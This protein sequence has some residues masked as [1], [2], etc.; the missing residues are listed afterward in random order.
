MN[1]SFSSFPFA[2]V[3]HEAAGTRRQ[4]ADPMF[5]SEG[6]SAPV[7]LPTTATQFTVDLK[8]GEAHELDWFGYDFFVD[9]ND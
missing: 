9:V 2:A 6:S 7:A 3:K 5:L 8:S 1:A 4:A